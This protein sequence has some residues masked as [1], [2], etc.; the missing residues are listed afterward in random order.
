MVAKVDDSWLWHKR[1]CHI[2]FE[3]IVK[4]A[5]VFAVRDLPKIVKLTNTIFKECVLAKHNRASFLGK[6]FTTTAKLEIVH[7]DLSGP[8]K[9]KGLYGQRYFMIIVNDFSRMMWVEFLEEK[10]KEFDK[11][12]IF[13]NRVE[14]ESSMK[15]K[16]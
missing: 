4:T 11:F 10:Y 1:F 7:R 2:N 6:K 5:N 14:N 16:C 15:I 8:I 13:K 9:T 12:K 3:S